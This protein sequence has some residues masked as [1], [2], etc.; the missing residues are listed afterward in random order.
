MSEVITGSTGML[1]KRFKV[2][3]ALPVATAIT[4]VASSP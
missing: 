2:G 4:R 3:I 1:V